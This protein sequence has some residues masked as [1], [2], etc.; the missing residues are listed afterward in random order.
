VNNVDEERPF[1][2]YIDIERLGNPENDGIFK[3]VDD[4]IV[5]EEKVDGGNGC[6]WVEDGVLH[7]ASRNRDLTKEKDEKAFAKTQKYLHSM[8]A[9]KVDILNPDWFYYIEHMVQ[10][11]I[12]YGDKIPL[13]I[14][15]DIKPKFG[16]F[17]KSPLFI[18]IK[19]KRD[20]FE[21]V[22]IKPVHLSGVHK[23]KDINDELIN[24]YMVKS[25]YYEGKPE[26]VVLKNYGR[27][28]MFGR[29]MFAKVVLDEFKEQNRAVFGGIKKDNSDTIKLCDE[30]VNQVRIRK[31]IL[32]LTTQ[33]NLPLSR[34]LMHKLPIMVCED[35]LKEEYSMIIKNYKDLNIGSMKQI[36]AKKC[37]NEIDW[38][39]KESVETNEKQ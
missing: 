14:G 9:G 15:L 2:K 34:S 18:G 16:A 38:M 10:H 30:F 17:G 37:L 4:D 32:Y 7:I 13:V 22:G 26:G 29:Q 1:I 39:I 33:E 12:R 21:R 5:I 19:A 24:S 20:E 31:K 28:N 3:N 23:A 27:M 6:I 25:V 8:F 35:V 36:V 11:T